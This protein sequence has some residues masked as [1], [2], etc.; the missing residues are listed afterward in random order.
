M[1][2]QDLE[3]KEIEAELEVAIRL[4]KMAEQRYEVLK[5]KGRELLTKAKG[6]VDEKK[7]AG[8]RSRLGL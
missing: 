5:E 8:I 4:V 1:Q 7:L 6:N 3:K 2:N